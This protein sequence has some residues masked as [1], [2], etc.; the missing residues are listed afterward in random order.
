MT[1]K[2][3]FPNNLDNSQYGCLVPELL[4]KIS[5]GDVID[6]NSY[7][8]EYFRDKFPQFKPSLHQFLSRCSKIKTIDNRDVIK[9]R[10]GIFLI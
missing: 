7:E 10:Y 5:V 1:D 3:I 8:E 2:K 4:L 6:M 9:K